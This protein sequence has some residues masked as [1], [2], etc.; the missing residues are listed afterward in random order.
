VNVQLLAPAQPQFAKSAQVRDWLVEQLRLDLVGP[1]PDDT[2][3]HG[4]IL[5]Q[6]PSRW[7][8][9][10][11]LVPLDAPDEQRAGDADAE[12]DLDSGDDAGGTD[13]A[14]APDQAS[15]RRTWRPS[16]MG[17]SFLLE[18]EATSIEVEVIWGDYRYVE[19]PRTAGDGDDGDGSAS[20]PEWQRVHRVEKVP[21]PIGKEGR[22]EH[23]VPNSNGLEL[24]VL[25]R[26]ASLGTEQGARTAGAVSVFLVNRCAPAKEASKAD[27]S[28]AFQVLLSVSSAGEFLPRADLR[29]LDSDD[30]DERLADLHYCDVADYAVGHNVAA[31]WVVV[32]GRCRKVM[33]ACMPLTPVP[34]VIPNPNIPDFELE[35]EALGQ[36]ADAATA[37]TKLSGVVGAYRD[38]IGEQRTR[39][40]ALSTKRQEVA[41]A[42]LDDAF[43]ASNRIEDGIKCLDR[44]DV[45]EAFRI[46][47]RAI[48]RAARQR[49]AQIRAVT[50]KDIP[51][52]KWRPF[53]LAFILLNLRGLVEPAHLD[54]DT[55]DLLF[56]PTGGG[57]T[58]AYLGLAAF[59]IAYRR[60]TNPGLTGAGLSV[61]MR[62]TL[63][64]LTLDQLGRASGVICALELERQADTSSPKKLGDWPIE[65]GLWV[66]RA[67][68]PNRM[69]HQGDND[70][71]HVTARWK[72]LDYLQRS[73]KPLPVPIRTCP[74]CGTPFARD[75]FRLVDAN[76]KANERQPVNL[77]LR[78]VNRDCEFHLSRKPL[79]ILT[80]DEPIYGRLPAFLIATVDKFAGM[81]WTGEIASF[82]GGANRCDG[83]RFF[84]AVDPVGGTPL[85]KPLLP[86]DLV[87]QDELH[88]ISGP[89]GTMVGLYEAALDR[90][91]WRNLADKRVRPKII[92]ST[93]TVRKAERQ[94][95]ALFDRRDTRIFPPPG[96]DRRDSF[97]AKTLSSDDPGARQYLGIAVPGGS[98]KVLFLRTVISLMAIAETA[99]QQNKPDERN[100]GDP[101]MTLVAYFN[102][103]RELGGARRIVEG[104]VGPRLL[105][106][107]RRLRMGETARLR[108]REIKYDVMELTSRVPTDAVADAKRRLGSVFRGR[109]DKDSVDVALA[110]NMISVG[111]D[112]PRLGLMVVSGQPKTAAEYIQA[113]SRVGREADK[114]GLVVVLLNINKP[115]DRSHYERFV[116]W[117]SAF[118]RSVE[119]TSVTPYSPRA[120]DRALAAVAVGL[121]RLGLPDFTPSKGARLAQAKRGALDMVA[122][123]I[124]A[125]AGAHDGKLNPA[126]Q[127][128]LATRVRQRV[129]DIL[130]DWA[131]IS[132]E[133]AQAGVELGYQKE[134]GV[135][136]SLLREMLDKELLP[137]Y[138]RKFRAPRSLRDVE[139]PVLIKLESPSGQPV[140]E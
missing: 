42:L 12:G 54:R 99:W 110:T 134:A 87:I 40:K 16:S 139:P 10:G 52:S 47:N 72:V 79:P 48:A 37:K 129:A 133:V 27:E 66:G 76:G 86:P 9:T 55:V 119:A 11:F 14:S 121:G 122:N 102:A 33:S 21:V 71:R 84:G 80:V 90:L 67:A 30:W 68:T 89:L 75:S 125:R 74:W 81:P 22:S 26:P 85:H 105:V 70:S 138:K 73:N 111:L 114:P 13:D 94:V 118:Y 38:W 95:R 58:E 20:R 97:F 36:L 136:Q 6:A 91:C 56:F 5:P 88:L 53:Q 45:L 29:G 117:H 64:L 62:Y 106:Y 132:T 28:F 24:S 137:P 44:P 107:G 140:S 69:G 32:E 60:L 120:L 83:V 19:M 4:E 124:A 128:A 18:A 35:M 3:M 77:E 15:A 51:A 1:G 78:C 130:D 34:R 115:R 46:A 2:A 43:A 59:T 63:R 113:T 39:T 127:T 92:V 41:G 7:Y 126:E 93:A 135:A 98:P 8:L 50:P 108:S 49:E 116:A 82:F 65:I 96:P 101:Y 109:K 104:E 17:L 57:K 61:L 123:A 25:V 103:L 23:P 112:I 31:E 100:P 131:R